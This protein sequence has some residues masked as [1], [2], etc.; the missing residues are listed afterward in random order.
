M[1]V[2]QQLQHDLSTA[3][4][5][6]TFKGFNDLYEKVHD[7]EIHLSKRKNNA[8]ENSGKTVLMLTATVTPRDRTQYNVGSSTSKKPMCE[9]EGS[10]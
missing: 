2:S 8:K 1:H 5:P 10:K 3:P 4:M 9:T 7:T 6:Q